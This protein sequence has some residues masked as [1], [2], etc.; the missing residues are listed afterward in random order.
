MSVPADLAVVVPIKSFGAAK[1]RLSGVLSD[2]NR[3]ALAE[4]C[5]EVVLD[6]CRPLPVFVVCDD[7]EVASWA[8]GRG[9][10]VVSPDQPGLNEAVSTGRSTARRHGFERVLVVH[11]DLPHAEP[12]LP[13]AHEAGDVVIVPDRRS[14]GTNAL[15]VPSTN[16]FVFHYG[17][18]SF[19]AHLAEARRCG[20]SVRVVS[21]A[22]LA[23]DVD[24]IDDLRA[25]GI[26]APPGTSS[27]ATAPEPSQK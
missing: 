11:G 3:R 22:D 10:R 7:P 1:S 4:R 25:A 23:L 8:R 6:A 9:A 16:D 27:D 21:R 5:A 13:L 19:D 24:T 12:L 2:A 20:L 15:L 14:D 18:G 17:P 26:V